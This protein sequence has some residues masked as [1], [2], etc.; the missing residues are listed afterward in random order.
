MADV[1][2]LVQ[3]ERHQIWGGIEVR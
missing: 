2:N 1:T 3:W